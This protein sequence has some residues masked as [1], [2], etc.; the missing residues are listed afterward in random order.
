MTRTHPS[1]EALLFIPLQN[2]LTQAAF[3]SICFKRTSLS[4]SFFSAIKFDASVYVPSFN[5]WSYFNKNHRVEGIENILGYVEE[6]SVYTSE[7]EKSL[8]FA[9]ERRNSQLFSPSWYLGFF[10]S[11]REI[12]G[13]SSLFYP[14]P[15]FPF[16][17]FLPIKACWVSPPPLPPFVGKWRWQKIIRSSWRF[18]LFLWMMVVK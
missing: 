12:S 5:R 3:E 9:Q 7:E 16:L 14:L 15:S 18:L 4:L 11:L 2:I 17:P 8:I 1:I 13:W 6:I 10:S